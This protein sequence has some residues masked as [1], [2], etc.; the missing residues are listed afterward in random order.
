MSQGRTSVSRALIVVWMILTMSAVDAQIIDTTKQTP[1]ATKTKPPATVC[2]PPDQINPEEALAKGGYLG[3]DGKI[4]FTF[5][6]E[7]KANRA[8]V[9]AFRKAVGRWNAWSDVTR[10][11]LEEGPRGKPFD[12]R[13]GEGQPDIVDGVKKE[14]CAK[15]EPRDSS[16]RYRPELMKFAGK[17]PGLAAK[18]Y[19]HEIGHVFGMD[20]PENGGLMDE[21][22]YRKSETCQQGVEKL[23]GIT[24]SDAE[25]ALHC[26][27]IVH[28]RQRLSPP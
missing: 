23:K 11:V 3:R 14:Y 22:E 19:V 2:R 16:V 26:A 25:A 27:F 9:K 15:Q 21:R 18:A 5:G 17:R 10:M 6:I 8:Q 20:H 24:S 7:P 28:Y 13:F 12:I 4:H 1:D